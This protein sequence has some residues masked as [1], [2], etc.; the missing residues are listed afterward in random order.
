MSSSYTIEITPETRLHVVD[1]GN[2]T[3]DSAPAPTT[4]VLLH[5]WG[6]SARTFASLTA[7]LPPKTFRTVALDFRGWGASSGPPTAGAYST[8]DLATDVE[9]VIRKLALT[10]FVLVG[11]SMGA[12]VAQLVAGRGQTPG[13][14][15]LVLL[16]PAPPTPLVLPPD[17]QATQLAAYSSGASAE[18]VVRNVLSA[19]PLPDATIA[20][21]VED[22][23]KGNPYAKAAWPG[24][25]MAED[26]SSAATAIRGPVLVLAAELDQVEPVERVQTQ[27]VAR[28]AGAEMRIV[29]GSGHLLP[30]EAPAAVARH[31]EDFVGRIGI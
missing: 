18:F 25:V 26:I 10:D 31:I 14:R 20:T 24:Y 29:K 15:G 28:I 21:T 27:V 11:H 30:L 4:L 1:S 23:L 7:A 9:T 19:S 8:A 6:G 22:M 17:M 16:A 13:L 5:F 3:E 2:S 12:K